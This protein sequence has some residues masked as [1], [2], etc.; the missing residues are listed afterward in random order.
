MKRKMG[1]ETE[2]HEAE[3]SCCVVAVDGDHMQC[4][5]QPGFL[6]FL[7]ARLQSP[8][9]LPAILHLHD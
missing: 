4:M 5:T 6:S 3:D 9:G 1:E 2:I 8:Q 7:S